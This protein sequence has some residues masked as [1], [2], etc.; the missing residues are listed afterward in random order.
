MYCFTKHMVPYL[1][2]E[3]LI[4]LTFGYL[5]VQVEALIANGICVLRDLYVGNR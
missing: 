2:N 5:E 4:C 3:Y 1:R